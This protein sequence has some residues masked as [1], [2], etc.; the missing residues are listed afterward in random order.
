MKHSFSI[1]S[2]V[3]VAVIVIPL[4]QAGS[5]YPDVSDSNIF[6][7]HISGL[8]QS[9]IMTGNDDGTFGGK[10]KVT[11]AAAVVLLYRAAGRTPDP[12]AVNCF[13]DVEGWYEGPVCDS[14][15]RGEMKGQGSTGLFKP[16]DPVNKVELLKMATLILGIPVPD[17]TDENR[18]V[19][20]F[21]D[22]S[23]AAWYTK[24]V[25]AAY[26]TGIL[27]IPGDSGGLFHPD[28]HLTREKTAA[29]TYNALYAEL[30]YE[31]EQRQSSSTASSEEA[32][33][34]TSQYS[35]ASIAS[36]SEATSGDTGVIDEVFPFDRQGKFDAKQ[37]VAFK[38]DVLSQQT[39]MV[40][41]HL[42][43]GQTGMVECRLYKIEESGFSDEYFLGFKQGTYCY[44]HATL[45]PG[46]YQLQLQ[47]TNANT[48]Y[49]VDVS[50][51]PGDGNDG[52]A[53]AKSLTI[54]VPRPSEL[55]I[56]DYEDWYT[57]SLVSE[58]RMTLN[59]T[60]LPELRCIVYAM[61]DVDLASFAG[62]ECNNIYTYP[63]GTYYI[64]VGRKA[65]V[66]AQQSFTIELEK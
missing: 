17:I 43:S 2:S 64:S 66:S 65:P 24:Y 19:V 62:P 57:F 7:D 27:P 21:A 18:D 40:D 52:F 36:S 22:L 35:S 9:G 49:T 12:L 38:F 11:R 6:F 29:I 33:S 25:Y 30:N 13:S 60:N 50:V 44:I 32:T 37:S 59:I 54:N 31:R 56:A 55:G 28:E 20:N 45:N 48:T 34:V 15:M 26:V 61:N 1:L 5:L 3:L 8:K 51:Q 23:P 46:T 42:Q 16:G 10:D 58:Q 39:V 41:A 14:A 63:P 47:P 53:E 4:A